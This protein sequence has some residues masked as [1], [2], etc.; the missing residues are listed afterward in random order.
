MRKKQ[1]NL[2]R[3]LTGNHRDLIKEKK[4]PLQRGLLRWYRAGARD[5]P[6]RRTRD[7]YAIWLSEIMLQQTRVETVV[8]YYNRFLAAFPT[9]QDLANAPKEQVMKQ[10]EGLGYYTRAHNLHKA[11]KTIA[12]ELGGE[13]PQTVE[14]WLA[15][16]GIGRYTAGAIVSIAYGISAPVLDGNVK[17]VLA[18]IF[19]IE[20][21]I[22]DLSTVQE[23]WHKA[24][25]L[26]S[27][28]DP[29][30]FNQSL[31]ELGA[32]IC[33]PR[34][35][36]CEICP[37]NKVCEAWLN[38]R[39][40]ELP[41]RKAKKK[42][43]HALVV[44]A[45]IEKNGRYLLGKRPE[46]KMLAGLWE[47]PGGKVEPGETPEEA[48]R[49]ELREELDIEVDIAEH[50]VTVEHGYSHL[51]VTIHLFR[52]KHLS[53]TPKKLYHSE[54]KWVPRSHFA[55]YAFPAA[56]HKFIEALMKK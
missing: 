26:I 43:P 51:S 41:I 11:A 30:A 21:S 1:E 5:L 12:H 27:K 19:G 28:S 24:E 13:F 7:P 31:M 6:W 38:D 29:G 10:W 25:A 32:R 34:N 22:D 48:L 54:I 50:I 36:R 52:C 40:N 3:N 23:L 33:I 2:N 53:G 42:I 8:D 16:P 35:P 49:R 46:G 39:Q 9:V 15:L 37:V 4:A 47:F 56:N 17:R 18:R 20:K 44:A 14:E 55:R 45:A